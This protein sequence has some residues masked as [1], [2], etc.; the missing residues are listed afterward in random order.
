[1]PVITVTL[2]PQAD[3]YVRT[4]AKRRADLGR[5]ISDALVSQQAR[6]QVREELVQQNLISREDW[7]RT[8]LCID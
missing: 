8:G 6:E 5:I 1:M 7:D 3:R 2:S 4:K